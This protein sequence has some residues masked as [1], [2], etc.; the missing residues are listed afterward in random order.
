VARWE[1]RRGA[2]LVW[3]RRSPGVGRR[4]KA[5]RVQEGV[6]TPAAELCDL[7]DKPLG[8]PTEAVRLDHAM[9]ARVQRSAEAIDRGELRHS[10]EMRTLPDVRGAV[11]CAAEADASTQCTRF[12]RAGMQRTAA[13]SDGRR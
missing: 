6:A 9:L 8:S 12:A 4:V 10:A 2:A 11:Q 3:S 7:C 5:A 1:Q 13:R